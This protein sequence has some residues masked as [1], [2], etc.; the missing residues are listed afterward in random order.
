[1]S[2]AAMDMHS[3]RPERIRRGP[4]EADAHERPA[5]RPHPSEDGYVGR[6]WRDHATVASTRAVRRGVRA[7]AH[8]K[9]EAAR[10]ER[11]ARE[12]AD[13]P[14]AI[15][16]L[17][18]EGEADD[19]AQLVRAL[20][21]GGCAP[22]VQCV[23]T[24]REMEAA[25][26]IPD[27][28]VVLADDVLPRFGPGDPVE[29]LRRSGHDIPILIVS[30]VV[31][32]EVAVETMRRGAA[33]YISKQ[34]LVR[35]APAVTR[36]V[37]D[38]RHRRESVRAQA[39]LDALDRR[40]RA[41]LQHAAFSI[42]LIDRNGA[43]L[44]SS[45]ALGRILGYDEAVWADANAFEFVH[46]EDLPDVQATIERVMSTPG[47]IGSLDYRC[48]RGDGG[49]AVLSST[50]RNFLDDPDIGAVVVNSHEI[51]ARRAMESAL[52]RGQREIQSLARNA[53]DI[54]A[55]FDRKL[56]HTFVNDAI[57]TY[58]GRRPE[59]FVGRTNREIGMPESLVQRWHEAIEEVFRTGNHLTIE[60]ELAGPDGEPRWFQTR[61]APETADDGATVETVLGISRD[62]TE[63]KHSEQALR[64]SE[65]RF[66]AL[67]E[68]GSDLI[69]VLSVTGEV[70][71][72]SPSVERV[73]GY[74]PEDRYGAS[75]LDLVHPDDEPR[76]RHHLLTKAGHG[77]V[78]EF[79]RFRVRH[80]DGSWRTMEA[81]GVNHVG[82]AEIGGIVL[83]LRDVTERAELEQQLLQAQKMEAIGRLA[84]G[85]AHDF[86][87]LLTVIKGNAQLVL[88]DLPADH[89]VRA[90]LEEIDDA[91]ERAGRLTGQLL[92]FSRRQV[93]R[94]EVI[95]PGRV[96][97][98]MRKMLTRMVGEDVEIV[99]EREPG[100]AR[101]FADPGQLE[102]VLMNLAVNAR[103]AMP[104]G[105][106]LAF[107]TSVVR[108][109]EPDLERP[110]MP[111]LPGDY[112]LLSV[113][114]SG[115]GMDE[116]VLDRLF[117]PFFTTKDLGRGTG[118]GL[119][120]VY[121]IVK[122]S[123]GA[124]RV[125]S[126]PGEGT[127]F[128]LHFPLVKA[129]VVD[130]SGVAPITT[131]AN[132]AGR[133]VLLAEDDDDVRRLVAKLLDKWGYAVTQAADGEDAARMAEVHGSRFDLLITDVVMP[134]MNG[135]ELVRR[136]SAAQ[137][138]ARVLYISG[139]P[140]DVLTGQE[141][142]RSDVCL[143]KKP[144]TPISLARKLAEVFAG[145]SAGPSR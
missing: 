44:Y 79:E 85:I 13:E 110:D 57:T 16:V 5:A 138:A 21:D 90:E 125:Q 46:P 113:S 38:A 109:D 3:D 111:L 25:L 64:R 134:S 107:L 36:E 91:S 133:S 82:T 35:L 98:E 50:A 84:G 72:A 56:R 17:L 49:W 135:A 68:H 37:R 95:D 39:A 52:R 48:R 143:L 123:G 115:C 118:L 119:S 87:N 136:F 18:V 67:I 103:D 74:S 1:M 86:N 6:G 53:P 71:Y 77:E 104:H 24:R 139:Y 59:E 75:G 28:D 92:A 73:L 94:P 54:L 126:V 140:D 12:T 106:R 58:T 78:L 93:L 51:S 128:R 121:G 15:R 145:E 69:F 96:L 47:A 66:R 89:A 80:R 2:R 83:H 130:R 9:P 14:V 30:G 65:S 70:Q 22:E 99:A 62:V 102:Q 26:Q 33:D 112:V 41:L 116:N 101:I 100:D 144:L 45:E 34:H 19:A 23:R 43:I 55:R 117:E 42:T 124:I 142:L 61:I 60:F 114:D 20:E 129:E 76:L 63:L 88:A 32:Q 141:I 8:A 137:P 40:Q 122:Q 105:G 97:D 132:A 131:V 108:I 29:V 7:E 81:T 11:P 4:P 120:T 31:D 27:W 10:D 127:T